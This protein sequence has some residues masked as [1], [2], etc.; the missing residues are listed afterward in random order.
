MHQ[1]EELNGPFA[2]GI[3]TKTT[4]TLKL[5]IVKLTATMA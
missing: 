4:T 3:L 1:V 2:K 5:V